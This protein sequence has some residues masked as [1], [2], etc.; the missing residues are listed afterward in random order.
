[1]CWAFLRVQSLGHHK[2]PESKISLRWRLTS[3]K[4][5]KQMAI[6]KRD[7]GSWRAASLGLDARLGVARAQKRPSVPTTPACQA[8]LAQAPPPLPQQPSPLGRMRC[9]S[10]KTACPGE[11]W[12]GPGVGAGWQECCEAGKLCAGGK[13][14]L[15]SSA[16]TVPRPR[17]MTMGTAQAAGGCRG[18]DTQLPGLGVAHAFRATESMDISPSQGEQPR[19]FRGVWGSECPTA[20]TL[21]SLW[22]AAL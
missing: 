5:P 21:L 2:S 8:A 10:G 16:H 6:S 19:R 15:T 20:V 18:A 4:P 14:G 22:A 11:T 12:P 3:Q 17:A 1:M 9:R 13:L 7:A